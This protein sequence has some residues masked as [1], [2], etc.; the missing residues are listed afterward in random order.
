MVVTGQLEAFRPFR[1][2]K[3]NRETAMKKM[4]ILLLST[5]FHATGWATSQSYDYP[6]EDKFV[7]R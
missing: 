6:F 2:Q 1:R 5:C 3:K 7:R 4:L